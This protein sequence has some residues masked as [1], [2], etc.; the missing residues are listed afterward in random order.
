MIEALAEPMNTRAAQVASII[1]RA[2]QERL[3][4]GLNDPRI[5]GLISVTKV[6]VSD[7]L[8]DARVFVSVLPEEAQ[9]LTMH[10]LRHAAGHL[11]GQI[12]PLLQM[13][14]APRLTFRLDESLKRLA[15]VDAV[16]AH[17]REELSEIDARRGGPPDGPANS[18][19]SQHP[20]Q[21][22]GDAQQGV[23]S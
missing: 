10:G 13:R 11:Q 23:G 17:V 12:A 15:R 9:T 14:R 3:A 7:D 21:R 18:Q 8:V 19:S 22:A 1:R 4:R 5:R 16:L 6:Q 20:A 2:E